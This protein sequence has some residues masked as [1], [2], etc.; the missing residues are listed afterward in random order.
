[1][2]FKYYGII[3][4]KKLATLT[5]ED[6]KTYIASLNLYKDVYGLNYELKNNQISSDDFLIENDDDGNINIIFEYTKDKLV[7]TKLDYPVVLEFID[8]LL[9]KYSIYSGALKHVLKE[10]EYE[11]FGYTDS[12]LK[13]KA[14][15]YFQRLF[16]NICDKSYID[17]PEI[18]E[19]EVIPSNRFK[20]L[21]K[22][23]DELINQVAFDINL[24][25]HYLKGNHAFYNVDLYQNNDLIQQL[26]Y[27]EDILEVICH[28]NSV[29]NF[30]RD[31]YFSKSSVSYS[32]YEEYDTSFDS[33][34]Q[35]QFIEKRINENKK[36]DRAFILALFYFFKKEINIKMPTASQFTNIVNSYFNLNIGLI[37]AP[38]SVSN[39]HIQSIE[40]LRKQ[41]VNYN[42]RS[43]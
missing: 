23:K 13:K 29:Y 16:E 4:P 14:L 33:L 9:H 27:F 19:G 42:S 10:F 3:D 25:E 26:I 38:S 32:I 17:V 8:F 12:E 41:W 28:F 34:E 2:K 5:E 1:M 21:K 11:T 40:K 39:S 7:G 15:N 43:Q 31:D 37:K 36:K 6:E 20:A 30:E 18:R 35:V 22:R 24:S